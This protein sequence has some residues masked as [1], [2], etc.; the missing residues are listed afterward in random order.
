MGYTQIQGPNGTTIMVDEA[1]GE[2]YIVDANGNIVNPNA[3]KQPAQSSAGAASIPAA[4]TLHHV[5]G[6]GSSGG[7]SAAVA[8][9]DVIGA[10]RGGVF[11]PAGAA[12][13]YVP[14]AALA[15]TILSGR[16]AYNML[17][18]RERPITEVSLSDLAKSPGNT[19]GRVGLG[20]ATGGLSEVANLGLAQKSTKQ[21]EAERRQALVDKGQTGLQK[22]EADSAAQQT[23]GVPNVI[24]D[25]S[26]AGQH[27]AYDYVSSLGNYET[28][29]DEWDKYDLAT[30]AK[31]TAGID[32]A[33]LYKN[34][35]GDVIVKD[36]AAAQAIA[37]DVM[38]G[39]VQADPGE[40][41]YI[42][43]PALPAETKPEEAPSGEGGG[44]GGGGSSKKKKV[45]Q[46]LSLADI[47]N[48]LP[49]L[50]RAPRYDLGKMMG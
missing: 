4:V 36:P 18:G 8:T 13:G 22:F 39:K 42:R 44:G 19:I 16:T 33:G 38:S 28:F 6:G 46:V 45:E 47:H 11:T 35:K 23:N 48:L 3:Q 43:N 41:P 25:P 2:S 15:Q 31:I 34:D 37:A 49:N 40:N 9:P 30:K 27:S 50:T 10:S 7:G 14:A 21:Y 12:P 26:R 20:V 32:Q 5:L 1:T 24:R 17:Q 29:G